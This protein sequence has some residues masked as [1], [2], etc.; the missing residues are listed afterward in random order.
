VIGTVDPKDAALVAWPV[1]MVGERGH[2]GHT[3]V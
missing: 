2:P 1:A 3:R